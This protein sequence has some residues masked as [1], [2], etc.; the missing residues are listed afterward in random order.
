M[1]TYKWQAVAGLGQASFQDSGWGE[2]WILSF[3]PPCCCDATTGC[4]WWRWRLTFNITGQTR[5][6]WRWR[7]NWK[8][9]N[10]QHKHSGRSL[11]RQERSLLG[12]LLSPSTSRG[13]GWLAV[14]ESPCWCVR[15]CCCWE[16]RPYGTTSYNVSVLVSIQISTQPSVLITAKIQLITTRTRLTFFLLKPCKAFLLQHDCKPQT[17]CLHTPYTA[18]VCIWSTQQNPSYK[19]ILRKLN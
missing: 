12:D 3:Y 16:W 19:Y 18:S 1:Q 10:T 17:F 9:H 15:Q 13:S 11:A 14:C 7:E 5:W 6:C 2:K 8:I 4:N